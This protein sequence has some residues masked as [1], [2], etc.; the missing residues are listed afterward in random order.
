MNLLE[1]P[2]AYKSKNDVLLVYKGISFIYDS[3]KKSN[4]NLVSC[5]IVVSKSLKL[6]NFASKSLKFS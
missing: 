1:I 2:I 4:I 6:E 5:I 3:S